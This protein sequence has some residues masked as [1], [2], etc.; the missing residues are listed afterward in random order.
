MSNRD[1]GA[2]AGVYN[3]L[4]LR[5]YDAGVLDFQWLNQLYPDQSF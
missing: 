5:L 1:R 3:G 4:T 2:R